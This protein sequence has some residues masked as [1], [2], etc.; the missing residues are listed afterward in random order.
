[1]KAF[2]KSPKAHK[3]GLF[4]L[5][6]GA[7]AFDLSLNPQHPNVA[8][9]AS[10]GI[11]QIS[12]NK[13]VTQVSTGNETYNVTVLDFG[14]HTEARFSK[15]IDPHSKTEAD[16]GT[17]PQLCGQSRELT[18]G[19]DDMD[20]LTAELT[21]I[22]KDA[23]S[24]VADSSDDDDNSKV[25]KQKPG[26][27][28]EVNLAEWAKKCD[29]KSKDDKLDCQARR[30][31]D[32]SK[33]LEDSDEQS[34]TV[35]KYFKKYVAPGMLTK[36]R[37]PVARI[38]N[39]VPT[40]DD[41]N[42]TDMDD[43]AAD[44]MSD[45]RESNG[46]ATR[47]EI[48]QILAK[49]YQDQITQAQMMVHQG[50]QT[51]NR[52]QIYAGM[53]ALNPNYWGS[54]LNDQYQTLT[55]GADDDVQE[56][57]D[58]TLNQ[59]VAGLLNQMAAQA[60]ASLSQPLQAPKLSD[61][62]LSPCISICQAYANFNVSLGAGVSTDPGSLASTIADATNPLP[63]RTNGRGVALTQ[64]PWIVVQTNPQAAQ[65]TAQTCAVGNVLNANGQCV[66]QASIP[67]GYQPGSLQ[68]AMP[69]AG[70]LPQPGALPQPGM[71]ANPA[72]RQGRIM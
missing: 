37:K 53:N 48:S 43:M 32:L 71:P 4:C 56:M 50:E 49:S 2:F 16:A 11:E 70:P 18:S 36:L 15:V 28:T 57:I 26:H 40:M 41:E 55:L 8:E 63:A 30:L 67:G 65:P 72:V 39:G 10:N 29:G 51:N 5:L 64:A 23:Q 7:L 44:L 42:L 27:A 69:Q 1:M 24:K 34:R 61:G 58:Q 20:K 3:W 35:Q 33:Y 25:K 12:V 13:K 38:S 21:N 45:L 60:R 17:C 66:P 9:F 46:E 54:R 14:D 31:V 68:P 59:P 6:A 47:K 52:L 19:L 62:L 22:V